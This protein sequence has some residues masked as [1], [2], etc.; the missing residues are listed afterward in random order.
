[1]RFYRL[2]I[3][4][5]ITILGITLGS[6]NA[7]T[8]A[9][10]SPEEVEGRTIVVELHDNY[11]EPKEI[12]IA[13]GEKTKIW[14]KNKGVNDHTFT[15]EELGVDVE[16]KPGVEKMV[17]VEP[18][19]AGTFKVICRFHEKEGMTGTLSVQ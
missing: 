14:L 19:K 2:I 16:L 3:T 8:Q 17:T 4:F 6:R 1:M 18:Q 12:R 5:A 10:E 15:V 9:P 13:K 7:L 11:F